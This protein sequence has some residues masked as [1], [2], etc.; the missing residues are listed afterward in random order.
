[1]A[2]AV[3][4]DGA[5]QVRRAWKLPRQ[6]TS[7]ALCRRGWARGGAEPAC[8]WRSLQTHQP[9]EGVPACVDRLPASVSWARPPRDEA[10]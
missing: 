2:P 4:G 3:K 6:A 8:L 10:V 1:M 7:I 5:W 9:Y